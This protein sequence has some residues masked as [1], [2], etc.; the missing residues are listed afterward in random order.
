MVHREVLWAESLCRRGE[1]EVEQK[2]HSGEEERKQ[3]QERQGA[4]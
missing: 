3:R 2:N 4:R 1:R